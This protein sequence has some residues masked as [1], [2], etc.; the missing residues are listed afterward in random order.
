[1]LNKK[2]LIQKI[3]DLLR[4]EIST[5]TKAAAASREA[6]TH[7]ESKAEDH[8]DTRGLEASYLAGA[9]AAR[10]AV[11]EKQ[12]LYFKHLELQDYQAHDPI[13]PCAVVELKQAGKVFTY[14]LLPQGGGHTVTH[15]EQTIQVISLQTP[16]GEELLDK[17]VGDTVEVE[18]QG[19]VKEYEVQAVQ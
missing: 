8:H 4:E 16:L 17:R 19:K 3:Q 13:G 7:E 14:F 18:V 15:E 9:Q 2:L 12:S 6:A 11:L 1:M 5:I 10:I